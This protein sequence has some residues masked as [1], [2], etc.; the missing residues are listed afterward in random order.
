MSYKLER[1]DSPKVPGGFGSP[2]G[3]LKGM[4]KREGGETRREDTEDTDA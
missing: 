3:I 1:S 4:E 2:G